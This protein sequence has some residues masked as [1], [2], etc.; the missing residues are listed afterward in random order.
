MG[1][2]GV[3]GTGD[4]GENDG[5]ISEREI[6]WVQTTT[7]HGNRNGRLDTDV[8]MKYIV[9]IGV[10]IEM[11]KNNDGIADYKIDTEIMPPFLPLK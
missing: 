4:P 5:I 7:G 11:D 10:H 1:N 2:D 8:E 9:S 3:A 6:D